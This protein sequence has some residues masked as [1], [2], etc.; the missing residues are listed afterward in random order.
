MKPAPFDYIRAESRAEAVAHLAEHGDSA[1]L[2]AGGQSLLAMLNMRLV[3][4]ELL[5][6]ISRTASPCSVRRC[7]MG[8]EGLRSPPRRS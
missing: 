1:R 2:L 6:D 3:L 5:I 4:P 8:A 7:S